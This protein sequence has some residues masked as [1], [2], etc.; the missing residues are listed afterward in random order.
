MLASP[1]VCQLLPQAEQRQS[2]T[3]LVGKKVELTGATTRCPQV[4]VFVPRDGERRGSSLTILEAQRRSNL[5]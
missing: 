4:Q 3:T 5:R 1:I 2:L